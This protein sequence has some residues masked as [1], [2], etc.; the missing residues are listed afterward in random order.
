M[1][2]Y[3]AVFGEQFDMSPNQTYFRSL[4]PEVLQDLYIS[5]ISWS[6]GNETFPIIEALQFGLSN[7]AQSTKFVAG[8][9][10]NLTNFMNLS[11]IQGIK[12]V[13]IGFAN[14]QKF[15]KTSEVSDSVI[16]ELDFFA[17]DQT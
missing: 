3:T 6:G 16:V 17:D 10:Q 2:N 12:S 15:N 1:G 5:Q 4:T 7:T 13:N 14:Y 11:E 8:P 9:D